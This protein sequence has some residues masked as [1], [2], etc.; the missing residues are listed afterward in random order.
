MLIPHQKMK[1]YDISIFGITGGIGYS[2]Y[3]QL[4]SSKTFIQGYYCSDEV[5]A[6]EIIKDRNATL[7]KID[8]SLQDSIENIQMR[9]SKAL[10]YLSGIP[11]F[12]SNFFE[13]T[14]DE[15][16]KQL[17]LNIYSLMACLKKALSIEKSSLRKII[18]VSS[19]GTEKLKS[20]YHLCKFLQEDMLKQIQPL[21]SERNVSV[22][23]IKTDWVDTKMF[24]EFVA[25]GYSFDDEFKPL[26]PENV[27][28][29]CLTELRNFDLLSVRDLTIE[30]LI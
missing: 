17:N 6:S 22:S 2:L 15:F 18:I 14:L 23:I 4:K 7:Q 24:K 11:N 27:A 3:K 25:R 29:A 21:L 5:I 1:L 9:N 12:S 8:L 30:N 26:P 28:A 20:V 19:V 16:R 13:F 10:V